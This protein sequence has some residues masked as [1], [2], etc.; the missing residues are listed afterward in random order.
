MKKAIIILQILILLVAVPMLSAQATSTWVFVG[1][2]GHL[3]YRTDSQGNRIMDFSW[4]GY[5]GGGVSL[6][7]VPVQRTLNPSGGDDTSAIQSAINAV[8]ALAPDGNGFRGA[9]LLGPGTFHISGQL[10]INASGVVLR[11]SGSGSGGTTINMTGSSG[12]RAISVAG[13]GSP[14]TSNTVNITDSYVPSGTNTVHVSS[15][16]GFN[17]G[18]NVVI[19]RVVTQAWIDFMGMNTLT[20]NGAPQTWLSPGNTFHTYRVVSAVS[21]NTITV[22]API[23]DSFD[24]AFL[25]TPAGT[26]SKYTWTTRISQD[27]VE[28]LRILAPIG[29]TVYSAVLMDNI[30]DAWIQ[31]VVGQETQNA[32]DVNIN[33]K[34][35]TV[36]RVINNV[37]TTQTRSAGT[38]DFSVTGT[39]VFVNQCQSN[40]TGDWPLVTS[41]MGTG[42]AAALNFTSTQAAG[43]SPHQRWYTGL[44]ADSASIPNAPSQT[45]GIGFRDRGNAGSGQGWTVG[46]AVAWNVNTPFLLVQEPPGADNWCIG[47]VGTEISASEPGGN[48]TLLP[49]GIFESTGTHVTPA[50]LYLAQLCDR[51]G[52][53]ALTNIGYSTSFCVTTSKDFSVAVS[54]SSQTVTIGGSTSYTAT[55]T[56]SGGFTG[57]VNLSVSGLPSGAT[58]SFSTNP[59]SGGSGT[60]TLNVTTSSTTPAGTYTLTITGTSGSLAHSTTVSLT[61]NAPKDFSLSA[62]PSS[63]TVTPSGGTSYTATV[64]AINGFSGS[65]G[66]SV[67]GLP[68]S[69]SGS[70]S[71]ASVSGSGSSTLTVSTTCATPAG[72]YP[73]TITG[74]SGGISHSAPPVTLVVTAAEGDFTLSAAPASQTVTVGNGASYTVT[75]ASAGCFTG[76]ISL[77]VSGLPAGVTASFNPTSVIGSGSSTLSVSTSSATVPGTYTLTITGTSG[78]IIHTTAVTLVVNTSCVTA[79]A[80]WQNTA[81]PSQTG[82]FTAIF[83]GTPSASPIN[84]VMALSHG[85]QTAYTGFATLA[86]FNPSGDIDA[87]NGGAYVGPTPAIPYSGRSTYHFRLVINVPAHTYSIFVTPPGGTELTVGTNFA[88][89][90]EQNTVTSL[91]HFGV[92]AATGSNTVCNFAVQ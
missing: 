78:S 77:S 90:T 80:A 34:Q 75:A 72:T 79:G 28:H 76:S 68:A 56:S 65:V 49:N 48:G 6:P 40:G 36:D 22:D 42:P 29:T 55:V 58:G 54:P 37:S 92:Y 43:I 13:S 85:A 69:A 32:F 87:R 8:S 57:S 89:R 83:D 84:S 81:I 67:S 25:G 50:S 7:V 12:F 60:S 19:N 15:T 53:A 46:W 4:A 70:F 10:N 9:L 24:S 17:V 3:H 5:K 44:L 11:G 26:I 91:D 2:D 30:I 18:D 31:D 64:S 73:L 16:S 86:R 66:L 59:I 52:P 27:G 38:A 47:C 35:V 14:S 51:L 45:P 62:A 82:T 39:Q 41:A 74:T 61:V 71:P 23:T 21:S 88:F 33:A 1:S 63:Q 20:R